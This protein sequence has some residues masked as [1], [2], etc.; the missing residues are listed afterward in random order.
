MKDLS[1]A[2]GVP[3]LNDPWLDRLG[4]GIEKLGFEFSESMLYRYL[5]LGKTRLGRLK[6]EEMG[7]ELG[8]MEFGRF[9]ER[10]IRTEDRRLHLSPPEFLA[11]LREV[12][13]DATG[14]TERFPFALISGAR[15]LAGYNTWTHHIEPLAERLKGNWATMNPEDAESL[16]IRGVRSCE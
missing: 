16:G 5:L 1:R 14:P 15:R 9:F 8:E 11:G 2:A 3:F 10:S 13:S 4:R 12:M 6:R 7:I